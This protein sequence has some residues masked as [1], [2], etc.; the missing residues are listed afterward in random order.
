MSFQ[1]VGRTC[2]V[3]LTLLPFGLL[4][5]F[6]K[7]EMIAYVHKFSGTSSGSGGSVDMVTYTSNHATEEAKEGRLR[8]RSHPEPYGK[9]LSQK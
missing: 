4:D 9:T 2:V 3:Y 1:G 5:Y 6:V 8:I 7:V